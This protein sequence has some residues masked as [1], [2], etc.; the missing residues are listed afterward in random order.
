MQQYTV[1]YPLLEPED[2][3]EVEGSYPLLGDHSRSG[4]E[5]VNLH[6]VGTHARLCRSI[7]F[8]EIA[9]SLASEAQSQP[10][11]SSKTFQAQP[12]STTKPQPPHCKTFSPTSCASSVFLTTWLIFPSRFRIA[13]YNLLRKLGTFL[14][15][16]SS[17][18][19]VTRLPF[20]LYLKRQ[21]ES[22]LSHNEFNALSLLNRH[23]PIPVPRPLDLAHKPADPSDPFSLPEFY[24]LTTRIPGIPLYR[25]QHVLSDTNLKEISLQMSEYLVQLRTI[26]R[27]PTQHANEMSNTL[28]A[29]CRDPRI[30]GEEP[31]GPFPDETSFSEM[32]RFPDDPARRGHSVV[33]THADLNPR[34][35]LVERD[36]H[37]GWRVTGIVDWENAGWYPEYWECTKAFFE[38]FRWTRRYNDMVRGWFGR[39]GGYEKERE[40]ERRAWEMGDGI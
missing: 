3:I 29:A 9:K 40:V 7:R 12:P 20:N 8:V 32:L 11:I 27:P 18:P 31:V 23:T 38:G 10:P 1:E 14:Y 25:C 13:I 34:N 2:A 24:L 26:P 22:A 5:K 17:H 33:F 28:G 19:T 37:K 36:G 15:G 6:F 39:F 4:I 16:P 21:T 30:R 35:I